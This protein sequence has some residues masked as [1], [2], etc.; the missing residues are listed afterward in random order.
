VQRL[1]L[2]IATIQ[3]HQPDNTMGFRTSLGRA[4]S[5]ATQ[6]ASQEWH[7]SNLDRRITGDVI[8][9]DDRRITGDYAPINQR[10]NSRIT[11]SGR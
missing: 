11:Y 6:A 10:N 4:F 9:Y 3:W 7:Q 2:T 5:A 8:R 1:A